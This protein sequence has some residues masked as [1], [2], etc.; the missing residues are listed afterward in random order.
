MLKIAPLS[1]FVVNLSPIIMF[2]PIYSCIFIF[3]VILFFSVV[4]CGIFRFY[5]GFY[6]KV[7]TGVEILV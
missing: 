6:V 7:F 4:G 1:K 2:N 3:T 5:L